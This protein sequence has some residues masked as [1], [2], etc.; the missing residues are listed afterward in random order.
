M[1]QQHGPISVRAV[2]LARVKV[3]ALG[4][5]IVRALVA[6]GSPPPNAPVVVQLRAQMQRR[7]DQR[8]CDMQRDRETA[9]SGGG[10]GGGGGGGVG[11]VPDRPGA[12]PRGCNMTA[13]QL[14]EI[15]ADIQSDKEGAAASLPPEMLAILAPGLNGPASIS[16]LL[17][18]LYAMRGI[19]E[20]EEEDRPPLRFAV[21]DAVECMTGDYEWHRGTVMA[22]WYTHKLD[23]C[24]PCLAPYLAGPNRLVSFFSSS[25]SSYLN[26]LPGP[27]EGLKALMYV[28]ASHGLDVD[29]STNHHAL[30]LF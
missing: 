10:S 18:R 7:A 2:D 16:K 24:E 17:Q 1:R 19:D 8:D 22:L 26:P 4:D 15:I 25:P 27:P 23:S 5:E 12:Q 20:A 3:P 21:G 6:A 30:S 11:W 29:I 14:R 9:G 28:I 13:A